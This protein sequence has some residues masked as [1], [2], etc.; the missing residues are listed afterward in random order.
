MSYHIDL[1]ELISICFFFLSAVLLCVAL[2]SGIQSLRNKWINIIKVNSKRYTAILNLNKS[3]NFNFSLQNEYVVY[4]QLNNK[5]T[6]DHYNFDKN[7]LNYIDQHSE[8]YRKLLKLSEHNRSLY[9]EYC[10]A[11]NNLPPLMTDSEA[12]KYKIPVNFCQKNELDLI[13]NNILNPATEIIVVYRIFYISPKGRNAYQDRRIYNETDIINIFSRLKKMEQIKN[14]KEFQ[15]SRMSKSL[16]YDVMKRDGFRCQLCGRRASD[17]IELHVD[18]I[19]PVSKGG[20]TE[21]KNL[22]TLCSDCNQGKSD[23]YDYYGEN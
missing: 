10:K 3:F 23:K 14:S 8:R 22:R 19:I 9:D 16:R 1:I 21:M 7:I 15:R 6:F 4:D 5:Q 17:N 11:I 18:H 20:K 12:K 13:H 2:Y